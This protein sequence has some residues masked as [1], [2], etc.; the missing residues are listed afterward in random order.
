MIQAYPIK[1][2]YINNIYMVKGK[3]KSYRK[4][5]KTKKKQMTHY[6]KKYKDIIN[7][8]LLFMYGY[9]VC[10]M[11]YEDFTDKDL[12]FLT[13]YLQNGIKEGWYL[14]TKKKGTIDL[15]CHS[16]CCTVAIL[17]YKLSLKKT[18]NQLTD[19]EK[20][21]LFF[22]Y[23]LNPRS[24]LNK[25]L[26]RDASIKKVDQLLES[27]LVN[28]EKSKQKNG[29]NNRRTKQYKKNYKRILKSKLDIINDKKRMDAYVCGSIDCKDLLKSN[30]DTINQTSSINKFCENVSVIFKGL[31]IQMMNVYKKKYLSILPSDD[32]LQKKNKVSLWNMCNELESNSYS[33][34]YWADMI[35]DDDTLTYDK[36]KELF[37]K[38]IKLHWNN[39]SEEFVVQNNRYMLELNLSDFIDKH[40]S[41][42]ILLPTISHYRE[43]DYYKEGEFKPILKSNDDLWVFSNYNK[44]KGTIDRVNL[45][46]LN[47][48][49]YYIIVVLDEDDN[50][51]FIEGQKESKGRKLLDFLDGTRNPHIYSLD[52]TSRGAAF[53]N[54]I[55][56]NEL[57][58]QSI[59]LHWFLSTEKEIPI[60]INKWGIPDYEGHFNE[61]NLIKPINL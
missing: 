26:S 13:G 59:S 40:R 19:L 14:L 44:A 21:Y 48:S 49:D 25:K 18:F 1:N 39:K 28:Y 53:N 47:N 22:I 45:N 17:N 42:V 30:K 16:L 27:Q 50:D 36:K 3:K 20:L 9:S 51:F 24:N 61:G 41:N 29:E 60:I 15:Q 2:L 52:K 57:M 8:S 6:S 10:K 46:Q 7:M 43:K 37:I 23:Y 31:I 11:K 56:L 32:E 5:K 55:T 35:M 58:M 38:Y 34:N 33:G 12:S 4:T 54:D